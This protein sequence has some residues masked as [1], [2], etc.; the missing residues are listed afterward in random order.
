MARMNG[1]TRKRL[2]GVLVRKTG[3][4]CKLCEEPASEITKLII[5]HID[6]DNS[7]NCLDNLQ[8]LCRKCNYRKNP[9]QPVAISERTS[10]EAIRVNQSKEPKFREFVYGKINTKG[11]EDYRELI[12]SGAENVG[13]SP[14]TAKRYLDKMCSD[15]GKLE[16]FLRRFNIFDRAYDY[17]R[18]KQV[19]T[20]LIL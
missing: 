16:K 18:Y 1:A 4:F 8:L 17:V 6:N 10:T 15:E 2:Y 3:D 20:T 19:R 5:D 7:N 11:S 12:I 14:I 9:R 13:I